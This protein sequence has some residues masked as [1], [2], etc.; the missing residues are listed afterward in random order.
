MA[1]SLLS[2]SY[3]N[4]E[5][6]DS[7]QA[8]GFYEEQLRKACNTINNAAASDA[9]LIDADPATG[10]TDNDSYKT[11]HD[12]S[13]GIPAPLAPFSHLNS[14]SLSQK[15]LSKPLWNCFYNSTVLM[16]QGL[17]DQTLR[18]MH[19]TLLNEGCEASG[20]HGCLNPASP[21]T[22]LTSVEFATVLRLL[23]GLPAAGHLDSKDE[24]YRHFCNGRFMSL[25]KCPAA[26][27]KVALADGLAH[28]Q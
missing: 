7:Y 20:F 28:L 16:A 11:T 2:E 26:K 18:D 25:T 10:S 14:V 12:E 27:G 1:L 6:S 5:N 3:Q 13:V 9:T 4:R 15:E 19:L 17:S 21:L 22:R 24:V 8:L 23:F